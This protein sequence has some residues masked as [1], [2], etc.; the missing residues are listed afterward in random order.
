MCVCLY[1]LC[2]CVFVNV[3]VSTCMP[4]CTEARGQSQVL[5]QSSPFTLFE[6]GSLLFFLLIDSG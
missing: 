6:T 5:D 3:N 1:D 4:Q 2:V